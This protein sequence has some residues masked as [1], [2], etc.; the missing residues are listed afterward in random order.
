MKF[1]CLMALCVALAPASLGQKE[2]RRRQPRYRVRHNAKSQQ[3]QATPH[4]AEAQLTALITRMRGQGVKAERAGE[5]SQ[6]FFSVKGQEINV[7]GENVQVF[8]YANASA[9]EAE[10]K[11]VS[12]DGG[13]VGTNM[14]SWMAPPHFYR[15]G[16]LIALYIGREQ[17]VMDA[18][19]TVLGPQFAGM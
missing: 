19:V 6:P 7:N 13:S 3:R 16:E 5:I 14:M 17:A 8:V 11:L 18:L 4:K 10:A 15:K 1:M 12:P 9:A 2:G